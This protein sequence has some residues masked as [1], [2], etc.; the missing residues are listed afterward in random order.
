MTDIAA[1][2]VANAKRW[3]V[4][5]LTRSSEF[6]PVAKRLV[7]SKARYQAV[8]ARTGVPW[9]VIA[10]IHERESDQSWSR[11][12]AQGDPWNAVSTH[13][14]AGRGPFTSW[15]AAATDALVSCAPYAAKWQD[16]TVGGLLTLLEE[17][18]GLGYAAKGVPSPYLWSGTDQY[19]AGKYVRDGVYDPTAI[20]R[21][22]GCAGLLFVMMALDP[23][24]VVEPHASPPLIAKPST[25]VTPSVINPA[26]GSIGAAIASL[27]RAIFKRS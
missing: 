4:A 12:L 17:Y 3:A 26:K 10:V 25:P 21:Q 18:N 13:V 23:S 16:W 9:F 20:D 8:E 27:L 22:L 6:N 14:P 5:K 24:I 15:E 11:S 19:R 2:K 7:A 1:L